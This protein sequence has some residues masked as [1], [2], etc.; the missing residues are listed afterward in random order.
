MIESVTPLW[1]I[2][3]TTDMILG[4]FSFYLVAKKTL[5][6]KYEGIGWWMGW[7]SFANAIALMLNATMWIHY[8]WSY[9]QIGILT[10]TAINMALVLF[11]VIWHQDNWALNDED[12]QKINKIRQLAKIRELSK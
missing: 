6:P 9:H 10:D 2:A 7:W 4:C 3:F 1:F 8:F 11:L 5:T 12:W